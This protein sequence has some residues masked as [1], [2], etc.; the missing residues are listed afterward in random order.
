EAIRP[1]IPL[2]AAYALAYINIGIFWTNHH[3]MLAT[4]SRVNGRALWANLFLLFWL[5]LMPFVIRWIGEAGVTS[6]P[7]AAYGVVRVWAA[8]G[9][10]GLERELILAEGSE[11]RIRAVVGSRAKE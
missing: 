10:L 1:A 8:S 5:T 9:Y 3:H 2:L 11:S 4:A 6:H 7:V